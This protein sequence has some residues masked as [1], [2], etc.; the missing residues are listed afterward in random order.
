M[1]VD[2]DNFSDLLD[3]LVNVVLAN[4]IE[5]V[6]IVG[7]TLLALRLLR[8]LVRVV[9]E[10]ALHARS[11]PS[12]EV[13]QK[14]RTLSVIVESTGRAIILAVATL[15]ILANIGIDVTPLLASAGIVGLG[16]SLGAQS[17]IRDMINGFLI[18]LED[19]FG[20]GD[21]VR[22]DAAIGTVE[23]VTL[24][25]TVLRSPDGSAVTIPNGDVRTVE[26]LSKGWSRVVVDMGV[27]PQAN[28]QDVL[29]VFHDVLDNLQDD[30]VLGE[31]IMGAPRIHGISAVTPNQLTFRAVVNAVPRERG[32]VERELRRRLRAALL[33][34]E[35]PLPPR[36]LDIMQ[37]PGGRR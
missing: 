35:V 13:A 28:D 37:G 30:P 1:T 5:I 25:R 22:I 9:I 3:D 33:E 12:R 18:L 27:D 32:M 20:V 31:K 21:Y 8:H 15:T 34:A 6:V 7:L 23:V 29:A 4:I 19:Q 36:T 17:L 24:R 10:R 2:Y 14:A 11:E 16:I 26:N